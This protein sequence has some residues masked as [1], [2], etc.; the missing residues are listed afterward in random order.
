TKLA[1]ARWAICTFERQGHLVGTVTGSPSGRPSQGSGLP[2]LTH[3][4]LA[5]SFDNLVGTG[6]QRRRHVEA[7]CLGG[8]KID[9]QLD[10]CGLLDRQVGRLLALENASGVDA[11]LTVHVRIA[12]SVAHQAASR[13]ELAILVDRWHSVADSQCGELFALTIEEWIAADHEPACPHFG[14]AREDGSEV[15]YSV[16]IQYMDLQPERAR[17]RLQ[18]A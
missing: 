17:R 12:T 6:E 7:E 16:R 3:D 18:L 4:E 9:E 10:F 8:L 5:S 1:A 13:R 2:I 15:A 11:D 14:Q